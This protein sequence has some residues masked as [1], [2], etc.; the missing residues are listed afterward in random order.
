MGIGGVS[1]AELLIESERD[2]T[3][4]DWSQDGRW[5][6]YA[7][8]DEE[9]GSDIWAAPADGTGEPRLLRGRQG[10]DIPGP[11]SPNGRWLA[12]VSE[13]SGAPEVYITP[14]PDAGRRWQVSTSSGFYPFWNSNG[15]ELVYQQLDGRVM[16]VEVELGEESVRLG[17]SVP[18]FD[19]APPE[20]IGPS[21]AASADC[22]RFLVI[23]K[24]ETTNTTLLNLMVGWPKVLEKN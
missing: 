17:E 24:G 1:E 10:L 16:S 22:E 2:L 19:L 23:P 18:L 21:F 4:R 7:R 20:P 11:I 8:S 15:R 12:Y 5:L 6:V 13:E 3:V 14:F 9:T